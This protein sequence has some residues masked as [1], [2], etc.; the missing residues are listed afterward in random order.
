ML[1]GCGK[2]GDSVSCEVQFSTSLQPD[3]NLYVYVSVCVHLPVFCVYSVMWAVDEC[4][5]GRLQERHLN[6]HLI[7]HHLSFVAL[8]T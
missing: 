3:K 4:T 8:N 2:L 5:E 6:L 7:K 1:R